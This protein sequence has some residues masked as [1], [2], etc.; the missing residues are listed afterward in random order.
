MSMNLNLLPKLITHSTVL[1]L[2]LGILSIWQGKRAE[3][4]VYWV[5]EATP[6]LKLVDSE[7]EST[8]SESTSLGSTSLGAS[9][10]FTLFCNE[11]DPDVLRFLAQHMVAMESH[12]WP[13]GYRRSFLEK[14]AVGALVSAQLN[15][16]PPSIIMSQAILESGWGRSHLAI[17][18]NNLF[19]IKGTGNQTVNI[20]TFE[21]NSRNKRY[22]KWAKFR[23]F[24]DTQEAIV[25]HGRL[26][27]KDRRY[28]RARLFRHDWRQFIELAAPYYASAPTYSRQVSSIIETYDLDIWDKI[29][30]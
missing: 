22:P 4:D 5:H 21:R 27:A 18:F 8:S 19:G 17:E 11:K 24:E 20:R 3:A 7:P 15:Q 9:D 28:Y 14:I 6:L 2:G 25:Y 26:L 12:R 16:I 30:Q 29:V 23:V 13:A 10:V 1:F